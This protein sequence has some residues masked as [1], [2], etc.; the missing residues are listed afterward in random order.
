MII[1]PAT[2]LIVKAVIQYHKTLNKMHTDEN[3]K[4]IED[5]QSAID[6]MEASEF[7][8]WLIM[9]E[10]G[11]V[12]LALSILNPDNGYTD[13]DDVTLEEWIVIQDTLRVYMAAA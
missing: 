10:P 6:E 12:S 11:E 13:V 7:K 9:H 1:I 4:C 5:L 2:D 3:L 8:D